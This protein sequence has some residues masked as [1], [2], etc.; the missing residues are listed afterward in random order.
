MA[1]IAQSD[2][3]VNPTDLAAELE[4]RAQSALQVPLQSLVDAGLLTR[5]DG[6]GRVFYRRNPH[7]IW[8]ASLDLLG[9]ALAHDITVGN[10]TG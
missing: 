6:L 7:S 1:A 10:P 8:A 9:Q 4:L 2:G 3:L 5:E